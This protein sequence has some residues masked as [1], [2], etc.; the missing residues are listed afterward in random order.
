MDITT[1]PDIPAISMAMAQTDVL[2]K[3]GTSVL[4]KTLDVATED[5]AAITKMMELSVNPEIGANLDISV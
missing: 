1:L 5:T 3:V 2:G 4:S